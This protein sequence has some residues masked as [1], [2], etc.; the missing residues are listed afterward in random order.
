MRGLISRTGH[1]P[2]IQSRHCRHV[3]S[4]DD[5]EVDGVGDGDDVEENIII[6]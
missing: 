2:T 4:D 6:S 5:D 1:H 3:P